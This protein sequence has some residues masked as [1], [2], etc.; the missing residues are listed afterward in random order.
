M[1]DPKA[2]NKNNKNSKHHP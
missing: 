2:Q 1:D